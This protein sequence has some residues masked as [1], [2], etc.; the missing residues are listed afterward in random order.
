MLEPLSKTRLSQ[1][2]V[3]AIK[4]YIS[5]KDLK[6]GTKL[7]SEREL[8]Q[9]LNISRASVREALRTLEIIGLIE[10]KPGSGIYFKD[11]T[12][13]IPIPLTT[14]LPNKKETLEEIFEVRQLIEPRAAGLAAERATPD[15]I[16]K[17]SLCMNTFNQCVDEDDMP[18]MIL[19]D[20]EFHRLV[21]MATENKTLTFLMT[22]MT[23]FLP[24]GWKATLKVPNRP[25][26]TISEHEQ[27]YDAIKNHDPSAA[28]Q[29][30]SGHLATALE[31]MQNI[32][33]HTQT[34]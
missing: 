11:W 29:A 8:C 3:E 6:P 25:V 1:S 26:K 18:G 16:K 20:T 14:W 13:D 15:I 28:I 23:R 33:G 10:V 17:L 34:S 31:E 4:S 9:A 12:G 24:E 7:P 21:A 19:A 2:A 5:D 22:T 27:I 32:N 30:M